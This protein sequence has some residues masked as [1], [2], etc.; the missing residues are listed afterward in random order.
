MISRKVELLAPVGSMENLFAAIQNGA[1]AVYLGG[2][3]FNA[4]HYASNF[5]NEELKFAVEYAHLR[6]V[7]VYVT[8]NIL[9]DDGEMNKALDYIKYLYESNVDGIIVQDLGL[10]YLIKNIFQIWIC[11]LAPDD[12]KQSIWGYFLEKYGFKGLY[13]QRNSL[14]IK[15]IHESTKIELEG[16]IH[17]ALCVCYSG[18][19]LMSSIIGAV[20]EIGMCSTL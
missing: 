19:C 10:A 1:D 11:M 17:G 4:R 20:V 9:I 14:E 12:N 7:K 6:N 16:F 2:K 15:R 18:Q 3:L 8:V 5:D 13:W